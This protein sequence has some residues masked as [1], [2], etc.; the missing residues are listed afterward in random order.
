MIRK[1]RISDIKAIH[2]LLT[3]FAEKSLLLPRSLS[4]LY[5]QLRDYTVIET[6]EGDIAGVAALNV[7]W[8][9]LAE[10][11]SLAVAGEYQKEGMGTRLVEH[12]LSEAVTLGI[13]RVFTLTYQP[14]FFRKLGF[15]QVDKS[16]LPHKVWADCVKCPKFPDC[17]ETAM[18]LEL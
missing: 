16:I 14:D 4:E 11:R 3:H 17:D 5:G 15:H 10:I 6:P 7:C 13:Y 12:C 8:D 18:L 9:N 2:A 1:A